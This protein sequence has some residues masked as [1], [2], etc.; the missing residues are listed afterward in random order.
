MRFVRLS[1]FLLRK[2][3]FESGTMQSAQCT[4]HMKNDDG[5]RGNVQFGTRSK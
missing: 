2:R 4:M 5:Y 1:N 3:S